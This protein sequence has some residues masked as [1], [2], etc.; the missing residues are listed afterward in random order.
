MQDHI[1]QLRQSSMLKLALFEAPNQLSVGTASYQKK[2]GTQL[3][4]TLPIPSL[5]KQVHKQYNL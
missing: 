3:V 5:A 2:A 1:T 4:Y